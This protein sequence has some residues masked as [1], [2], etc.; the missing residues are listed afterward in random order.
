MG[1]IGMTDESK[2][3]A[4]V[5]CRSRILSQRIVTTRTHGHV[6][7]C[8]TAVAPQHRMFMSSPL[9]NR[10]AMLG[11]DWSDYKTDWRITDGRRV[12]RYI[13]RRQCTIRWV[14]S[15]YDE[16]SYWQG[17]IVEIH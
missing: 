15:Q 14:H 6:I 4:R 13:H 8:K 3:I 17:T 7:E 9:F 10:L 5:R 16:Q 11:R 1:T 2:V 12:C